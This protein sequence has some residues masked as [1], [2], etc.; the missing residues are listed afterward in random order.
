MWIA[1]R[2]WVDKPFHHDFVDYSEDRIA[3]ND[4]EFVME[5][6]VCTHELRIVAKRGDICI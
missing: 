2:E 6:Q 4:G 3:P 5:G 1:A